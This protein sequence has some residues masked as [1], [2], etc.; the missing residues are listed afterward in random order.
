M[1]PIPVEQLQQQ[2]QQVLAALQQ[3]P[4]LRRGS[5]T[6]QF[7]EATRQD[8]SKAK[9]GPYFIYS[10]KAQQRTVSRYLRDPV[11]IQQYR[12]QIQA[13]RQFQL[14]TKQLL[15]L[16]EQLSEATLLQPTA[17]K[18]TSPSKSSNKRK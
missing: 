13:F 9:R 15:A 10:Y 4:P 3:L 18:K 12:D 16:G 2:R 1:K 17:L 11:Q 7:V 5:V 8:G 14:L 6:E